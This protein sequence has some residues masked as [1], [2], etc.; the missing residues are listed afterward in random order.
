MTS[1]DL[2]PGLV[3]GQTLKGHLEATTDICI[4][5][6]GAGGA[7]AAAV[8]GD[9]GLQVM[10]LEEGGYFTRDR[11][12]M[13]E[14]EAFP[15]LYQEGGLRSTE[16]LSIA[17][18]QGRAVGGTTVVNWTT[19][20]RTPETVIDHW[21]ERFAVRGIDHASLVPHWEQVERRLNIQEIPLDLVNKSNRSLYEGCQALG[22]DAAPL[23]RNVNGCARTGYCGYGCP[24]DA[25]Q[26]MLVTYLPD[27][28]NS[29]A[30]VVS[31]VR[32]DRFELEG[33]QAGALH[34]TLLDAF[35]LNPT[36]ATLTV[37]AKR[38]ILSAGA[39]GTPSILLRSGAPDPHDRLGRR[40][41]LHPTI[42]QTAIFDE[43][44]EG[45]RGAPQG[46]ASH[47]FAHRGDKVGF[48]L[49][50]APVQPALISI[51]LPGFGPDHRKRMELIKHMVPHV[52]L[53][54]DG[55]HEGEEGGRVRL[56]KS[57]APVLD[58]RVTDKQR[59]AMREAHKTMAK[60]QL[61][62]GAK[63]SST[64]HTN[65]VVIEKEGDLRKL[66]EADYGSSRL[67]IFSAHVMGG[68]GMSDDPKLGV[69][70]SEDLRHHQLRNVHVIDGSVFPTSLGV[71]PQESI[72]GLAH[73]VATR[74][75]AAWS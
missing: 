34:C 32:V 52:A 24:I 37:H 13:R 12:R 64:G 36:G 1:L 33:D 55:H 8:L 75:A 7:V 72:Y 62:A 44:V 71:N 27:A 29:G 48:F 63:R 46:V 6:S 15:Q 61:A 65:L 35:G 43:L 31:R 68:A 42:V 67:G 16:D 45:Y 30:T 2:K 59:E 47:H 18:F 26:S 40:T 60:I 49:E 74:L 11:F 54:I 51:A 53:V 28:M 9:K 23:R 5:G 4:I 25:K 20:F 14:E 17:V 57:G 69:V 73:L 19:C 58:Y 21:R 22:Y 56:R 39:I 3:E 50:A 38:F 10:V 70:R 66:D 41:F